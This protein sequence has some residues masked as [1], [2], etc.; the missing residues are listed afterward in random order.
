[1]KSFNKIADRLLTRLVPPVEAQAAP[2]EVKRYPCWDHSKYDC[3]YDQ[4]Q[5]FYLG[6]T[7]IGSC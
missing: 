4:C 7:R 3:W 1:M 6:C 2:C 5:G